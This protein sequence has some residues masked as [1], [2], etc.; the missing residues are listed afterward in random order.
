MVGYHHIVDAFLVED[1]GRLKEMLAVVA[2]ELVGV[3][4]KNPAKQLHLSAVEIM[5]NLPFYGCFL[6]AVSLTELEVPSS[7]VI[8]TGSATTWTA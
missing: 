4:E 6:G 2:N 8:S 1:T 3:R 5:R 7:R